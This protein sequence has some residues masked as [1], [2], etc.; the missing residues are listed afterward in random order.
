MTTGWG[1]GS[2]NAPR[3]AWALARDTAAGRGPAAVKEIPAESRPDVIIALGA[4]VRSFLAD[5]ALHG[6]TGRPDPMTWRGDVPHVQV[7]RLAADALR[8]ELAVRVPR[9]LCG[10]CTAAAAAKMADTL[11][12]VM[13][14]AGVPPRSLRTLLD[15][16]AHRAR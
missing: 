4:Q 5:A 1:A 12:D 11:L 6:V 10:A 14:D 8:G 3:L 13:T 7:R 2:W 15:W 16:L 9:G